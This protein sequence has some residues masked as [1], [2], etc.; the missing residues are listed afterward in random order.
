MAK[1]ATSDISKK[2]AVINYLASNPAAT[3]S[4]VVEALKEQGIDVTTGS[5]Y[6]IKWAMNRDAAATPRGQQARK[7][8]ARSTNA[9]AGTQRRN[10]Q[11]PA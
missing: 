7:G 1:A 2:Q 11:R 6:T 4:E 8:M 5:V 9:H 3:T 10:L